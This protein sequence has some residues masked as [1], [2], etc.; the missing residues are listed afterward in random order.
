MSITNVG[1]TKLTLNGYKEDAI[2]I[3]QTQISMLSDIESEILSK[4]N[5][6]NTEDTK[7]EGIL[8]SETCREFQQILNGEVH[9]L[10]KFDVVLAVVGTMKAGKSTTIKSLS[11]TLC[12]CL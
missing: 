9:K 8:T 10:Q 12:N 4:E 1:M 3:L 7:S 11:Q 2:K 5:E 6:S